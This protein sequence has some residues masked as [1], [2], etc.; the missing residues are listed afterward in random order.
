MERF[1]V[2]A[3]ERTP[4]GKNVAR[5][6]RRDGRIPA[7]FYGKGAAATALAVDP[8]AILDILHSETGHNTIFT[9]RQDG[10]PDANVLIKEYQVDP[11]RG[12]LL[13]VDLLRVAMD[14]KLKLRVPVEP[15]G[16]PEGVKLQGGIL[17]VV[18]KEIEIECLPADIPDH[19]KIDVSPLK[20]G[21]LIRVRD[22]VEDPKVRFL[23]DGD[24]VV[25][26]VTAPRLE[27]APKP[28]EAVEAPAATEPEVIKKGKA[29][30]E[31]GAEGAAEKK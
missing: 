12:N 21:D 28:E 14:V 18:T 26:T 7:V 23:S 20:I 11:V 2:E 15:Q 9:I 24:V 25:V 19:I 4:G 22:L 13:H 6:L 27:E 8:R 10:Q 1:T 29:V 31:E 5:R 30:T 16:V 17:D 3:S